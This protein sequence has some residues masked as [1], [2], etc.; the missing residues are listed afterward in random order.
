[1]QPRVSRMFERF[2]SSRPYW[3]PL[4][5][6]KAYFGSASKELVGSSVSTL[7]HFVAG[8]LMLIGWALDGH[9]LFFRLGVLLAEVTYELLDTIDM[10]FHRGMWEGKVEREAYV[11]ILA[12]HLPG[13]FLV[14]PLNI[15]CSCVALWQRCAMALELG[16]GVSILF[17]CLRDPLNKEKK[18]HQVLLL[19]LN[20]GAMAFFMWARFFVVT[21]A[22]YE[23]IVEGLKI[24]C[25]TTYALIVGA[26][27]ITLFNVM[28]AGDQML[29]VVEALLL[30]GSKPKT[31]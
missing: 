27:L 15:W 26:I 19:A 21:P 6:R 24:N 9:T 16:G 1:M 22:M 3:A 25:K 14:F 28:W 12:H 5:A 30:M 20:V 23:I 10:A 17:N 2:H 13:I 4:T 29:Q 8:S 7:Q 31:A 11:G 18:V